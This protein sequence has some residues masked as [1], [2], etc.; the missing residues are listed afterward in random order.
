MVTLRMAKTKN[1][2]MCAGSALCNMAEPQFS[3]EKF[4][5]KSLFMSY[6]K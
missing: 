5:Q 4:K 6:W 2:Q 1:I 3:K